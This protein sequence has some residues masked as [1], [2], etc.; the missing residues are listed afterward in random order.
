MTQLNLL[1]VDDETEFVSTLAERLELRGMGVRIASDGEAALPMV[2]DDP[3][4]IIVLD[5]MMPGI[6]GMETLK[7]IK[8]SH[9]D[10]PVILLTGR[11]STKEGIE[12]MKQ[13]AFDYMMKPINLDQL[14]QKLEEAT[15][16][17]EE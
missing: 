10:I 3:P 8:A 9:P 4:D 12:G 15:G 16:S 17:A 11:G 1:L 14:L 2:D 6:G 5:L 7:R 13:G